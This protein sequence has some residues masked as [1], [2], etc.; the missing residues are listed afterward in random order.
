M[1]QEV[2]HPSDNRSLGELF[3]DLAREVKTL[4][5][6]EVDLAKTEMSTKVSKIGKPAGMIAA[7]GALAYAG[8]L[9]LVAGLVFLFDLWM[10][11]WVSA[12][13]VGLLVAGAGGFMAKTGLDDLKR[14]DLVPRETLETLKEDTSAV[15]TVRQR[16]A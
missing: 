8:L 15:N 2:Q 14:V 4:V 5:R 13:L 7:G 16:A 10:P 11:L 1:M 3:G 9:A 12:F 6:Q